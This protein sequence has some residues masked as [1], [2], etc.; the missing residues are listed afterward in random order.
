MSTKSSSSYRDEVQSKLD[1]LNA[2]EGHTSDRDT[3]V[4]PDSYIE[5]QTTSTDKSV[6]QE[7]ANINDKSYI[8]N[9]S[10]NLSGNVNNTVFDGC[11]MK[12]NS[13]VSVQTTKQGDFQQAEN[14]FVAWSP[15][16]NQSQENVSE[17]ETIVVPETNE[18]NRNASKKSSS[19]LSTVQNLNDISFD[20]KEDVP[21]KFL[22]DV[23]IKKIVD[24]DDSVES[25]LEQRSAENL[26]ISSLPEI[27][28]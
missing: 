14:T 17:V 21:K 18:E 16:L 12:I 19:D 6:L 5:D 20:V 8:E 27:A 25:S 3:S 9:A 10:D 28:T 22:P 15:L 24:Y 1:Q 7:S 13:D 4:N 23:K 26:D 11:D 2:F